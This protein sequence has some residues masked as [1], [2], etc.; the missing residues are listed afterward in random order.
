MPVVYPLAPHRTLEQLRVEAADLLN[1]PTFPQA[2]QT[3][4]HAIFQ[5]SP[6]EQPLCQA[7]RQ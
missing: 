3:Y 5:L 6:G 7:Y 1:R 2:L 4:T